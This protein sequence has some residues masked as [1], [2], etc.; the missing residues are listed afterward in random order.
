MKKIRKQNG[1]TVYD[2]V[3][4]RDW[5]GV[6]ANDQGWDEKTA[7]ECGYFEIVA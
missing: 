4:A 6:E 5:V 3:P 7:F 1:I 2:T